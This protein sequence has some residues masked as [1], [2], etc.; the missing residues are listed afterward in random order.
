MTDQQLD[1]YY[2]GYIIRLYDELGRYSSHQRQPATL[3]GKIELCNEI[4]N[5]LLVSANDKEYI[6]KEVFNK[7]MHELEDEYNN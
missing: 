3:K 2:Y 7:P 6:I 1:D 4:K 5:K